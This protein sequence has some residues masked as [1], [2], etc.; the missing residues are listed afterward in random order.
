MSIIS[1][2]QNP[3]EFKRWLVVMTATVLFFYTF[4][5]MNMLNPIGME[6]MRVFDINARQFGTL[7][8]M[9]FYGNFIL[10]FPAGLLLDRFSVKKIL[11]CALI[12][13]TAGMFVFA[14]S[15]SYAIAAISR[16]AYGIAGSFGFLSAIRLASR[17]F[18]PKKLALVSG[19]IVTFAMLGGVVAQAPME[20]LTEAIGWRQALIVIG[21]LGIVLICLVFIIVR[22]Y[23]GD[24]KV[25][26]T[27]VKDIAKL[28]FWRSIRMVVFNRYNWIGGLYTTLMNLPIFTLGT[29]W[30][31]MYLTQVNMLSTTHAAEV[32]S[33]IFLGTLVGSP[34]VGWI[35]DKIKLRVAPMFVGA[36]LSLA[37]IFVIM[38]SLH[39]SF[40]ILMVLFFLLGLITATQVIGYPVVAELNSPLVTGSAISIV[41]LLLMASGFI[42]QPLFGWFMDLHW[43]HLMVYGMRIYS[44][45]DF[46]NALWMIPIGFIASIVLSLL[47]K[48]T[49]GKLAYKD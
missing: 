17:W 49:H 6:L 45:H 14:F 44:L 40:G 26:G 46:R 35:S 25:V 39:L 21:V 13:A 30:G 22:D 1:K 32:D 48:E 12:L 28:G 3:S 9:Y 43:N 2:H 31:S 41:S 37:I 19:C 11:L 15:N 18:P 42:C 27:E 4:I 24:Y 7:S 38:Y 29:L 23:P 47:I 8:S 34:L 5:Q 16:F 36:V 33:M 10:L 20:L